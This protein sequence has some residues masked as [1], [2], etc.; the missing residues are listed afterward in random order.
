[1]GYKN[2][3]KYHLAIT[4]AKFY[5]QKVVPDN[6]TGLQKDMIMMSLFVIV[7]EIFFHTFSDKLYD[8]DSSSMFHGF[9]V[10]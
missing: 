10:L 2:K 7:V 9:C 1:M 8:S 3:Y 5:S 6:E 4:E